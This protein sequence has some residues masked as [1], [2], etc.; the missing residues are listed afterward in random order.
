MSRYNVGIRWSQSQPLI[1]VFP[2][3]SRIPVY[4]QDRSNIVG[5]LNVKQL[6]LLDANDNLP[7]KTVISYY[8]NQLFFVFENTR[9]DY[10]FRTFRGGNRGHMAFVQ[11]INDDG[12]ADPYYLTVGLV[13][14][15]DVLEELLQAE[16]MD[17]CDSKNAT[18]D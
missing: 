7:L 14:F 17:E 6:T 13:T 16:I 3:Y 12:S 11:R 1:L 2:G 4:E 15:E 8:Q 18:E 10:M 9:L 5:L